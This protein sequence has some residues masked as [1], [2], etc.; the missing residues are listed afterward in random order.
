MAHRSAPRSSGSC[1]Q[2][3][4]AKGLFAAVAVALTAAALT[5]AALTAAGCRVSTATLL[6]RARA[7]EKKGEIRRACREYHTALARGDLPRDQRLPT[8]RARVRCAQR[9][10]TLA[11]LRARARRR[12]AKEPGAAQPHYVLGLAALLAADAP[13]KLALRHLRAARQADPQRAEYP[14]RQGRVLIAAERFTEALEPLGAATRLEPRWASPRIARAQAQAALGQVAAVRRTLEALADC[15]PTARQVARASGLLATVARD[16]DPIPPGA[17][18]R[19]EK[20]MR[21]LDR[22][23]TAAAAQSLKVAHAEYPNVGT[24]ALLYGLT[25]VRLSNYGA[26]LTLLR[27]AAKLNPQDFSAPLHLAA[28][29]AQLGR[30][31]AAVRRYREA[32]RLNPV[33]RQAFAGLG[34]TLLELQRVP[35]ALTALERAAALSGDDPEALRELANALATAGRLDEAIAMLRDAVRRRPKDV[36]A[37][38]DLAEALIRRYRTH[39]RA[40]PAEKDFREARRILRKLVQD[41]PEHSAAR[42]LL[43]RLT[44]GA[45]GGRTP[46]PRARGEWE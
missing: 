26:A 13:A 9:T 33:S 22:E 15:K 32:T 17:Q 34:A 11:A 3:A 46:D 20:I 23:F 30:K 8:W 19:F 4:L 5:A 1:P 24:F 36:Q 35:E 14:Y 21:L 12:A 44:G 6:T 7:H 27:K 29:L 38:F 40:A 42:K 16:A 39:E 18:P 10:G 31:Q 28:V 25:M 2:H 41:A 43:R 45:E 37:R